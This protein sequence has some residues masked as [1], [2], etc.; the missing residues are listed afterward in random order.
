[1]LLQ[2]VDYAFFHNVLTSVLQCDETTSLT[3]DCLMKGGDNKEG[4]CIL[5]N[6]RVFTLVTYYASLCSSGISLSNNYLH[7]NLFHRIFLAITLFTKL[8]HI[9]SL[10]ITLFTKLSH[11]ISLSNNYLHQNLFHR[12]SLAITLSQ[13][14]PRNISLH[15]SLSQN[16]TSNN[17]LNQT[18]SPNLSHNNSPLK[19][20]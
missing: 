6:T 13:N 10:A 17:S 18:L 7:Q 15:Q 16:I 2:E 19:F 11:R 1:M 4:S 14:L 5:Y 3:G 12:I 9:I 20:D 8:S